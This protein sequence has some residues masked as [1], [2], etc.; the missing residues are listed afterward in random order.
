[1]STIFEDFGSISYIPA[2]VAFWST[3]F[4]G[5]VCFIMLCFLIF[6]VRRGIK[7]KHSY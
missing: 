6:T 5:V 2:N 3:V 1:M 4:L 7:S